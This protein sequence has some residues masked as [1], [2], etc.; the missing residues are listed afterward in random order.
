MPV[1]V[2]IDNFIRAES[3]RM[4]ASF[5]RDAGGVNRLMHNREPTPIEHQPVIRMNRDTLY[6]VAVVDISDG[7]TI[8]VPD[9]GDR[10]VSAMVV[11]QEAFVNRILHEPGEHP[12]TVEEFDTPWVT[13]AV[14]ILADPPTRRTSRR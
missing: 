8:T 14:R 2:T 10:Y 6:S 9:G 7:A 4:F 3:D 13:V 12:L 5:Q 11:N 1:P